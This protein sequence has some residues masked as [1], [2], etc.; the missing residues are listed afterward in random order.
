[1]VKRKRTSSTRDIPPKDDSLS[2]K[3][4]SPSAAQAGQKKVRWE[5][6]NSEEDADDV[7]DDEAESQ[8]SNSE[9]V[10][11]KNLSAC[12]CASHTETDLFSGVLSSVRY[13]ENIYF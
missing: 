13:L 4:V 5:G 9:K 1:M 7:T 8:I 3:I 11:P 6:S 12:Y 10:R 2:A